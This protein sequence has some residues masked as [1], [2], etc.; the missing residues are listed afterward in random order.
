MTCIQIKRG[1]R[2]HCN[3]AIKVLSSGFRMIQDASPQGYCCSPRNNMT[4]LNLVAPF[5]ARTHFAA[6][7]CAPGRNHAPEG[8]VGFQSRNPGGAQHQV[9]PSIYSHVETGLINLPKKVC[10]LGGQNSSILVQW[11]RSIRGGHQD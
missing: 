4:Q 6:F 7:S 9:H 2:K 10:Y 11:E 1:A 5:T 3:L 8:S